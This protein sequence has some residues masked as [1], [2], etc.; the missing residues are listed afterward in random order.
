MHGE[1]CR[2]K[3]RHH[4][5]EH[6]RGDIP[7][8]KDTRIL[9]RIKQRVE[10]R[11][12]ADEYETLHKPIFDIPDMNWDAFDVGSLTTKY[13]MEIL[14]NRTGMHD[15]AGIPIHDAE[16]GMPLDA[17]VLF[18]KHF[19][20][21]CSNEMRLHH[22]I[23]TCKGRGSKFPKECMDLHC[24]SSP[25]ACHQTVEH[26]YH[27]IIDFTLSQRYRN[28]NVAGTGLIQATGVDWSRAVNV[29]Q[30]PGRQMTRYKCT[31]CKSNIQQ[32]YV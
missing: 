14:R 30:Q 2:N 20:Q 11:S 7:Y 4:Y 19:C 8:M 18:P 25:G 26:Y 32:G 13:S 6:A 9:D 17:D 27:R 12:I 22:E 29:R 24:T 3:L 28:I 16:S 21:V 5:D 10:E 1:Q 23:A 31:H 15:M